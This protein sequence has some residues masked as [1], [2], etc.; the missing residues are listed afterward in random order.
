MQYMEIWQPHGSAPTGGSQC[1]VWGCLNEKATNV[2]S[3]SSILITNQAGVGNLFAENLVKLVKE[4]PDTFSKL[5]EHWVYL[6]RYIYAIGI[7]DMRLDLRKGVRVLDK[8]V[9][10]ETTM[11]L[12]CDVTN[13]FEIEIS[14]LCKANN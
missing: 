5:A 13:T 3:W 6:F 2:G 12:L 8:M 11:H 7:N 9:R 10:L 1:A 14:E 4:Y